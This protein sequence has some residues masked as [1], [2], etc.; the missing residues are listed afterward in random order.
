MRRHI[1]KMVFVLVIV[2]FIVL[3]VLGYFARRAHLETE[4]KEIENNMW[5][6]WFEPVNENVSS[7]IEEWDREGIAS[8]CEREDID[9]IVSNYGDRIF[10]ISNDMICLNRDNGFSCINI[11]GYDDTEI[12]D[13]ILLIIYGK[14]GIRIENRTYTSSINSVTEIDPYLFSV[15]IA[16]FNDQ[17]AKNQGEKSL[18]N[19][20]INKIYPM[21]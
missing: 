13:A 20:W 1:W 10:C 3:F 21:E 19:W 9:E 4:K 6:S 8:F 12:M 17:I 2:V 16:D 7:A 5:S 18:Q 15:C 11:S 14:Q